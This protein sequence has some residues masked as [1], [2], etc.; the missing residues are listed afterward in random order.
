MPQLAALIHVLWRL[1][2]WQLTQVMST[3]FYETV[4]IVV[5]WIAFFCRIGKRLEQSDAAWET[6]HLLL[7]V[8]FIVFGF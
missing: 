1:D 4:T 3:W 5:A 8:F 6:A 2:L 7:K